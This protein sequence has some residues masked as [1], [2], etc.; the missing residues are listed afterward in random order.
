MIRHGSIW[1]T[2]RPLDFA[3]ISFNEEKFDDKKKI[4]YC[5]IR[6]E[7]CQQLVGMYYL[8]KP[9]TMPPTPTGTSQSIVD[10]SIIDGPKSTFSSPV[11][12]GSKEMQLTYPCGKI[13]YLRQSATG[14]I[15]NKTILLGEKNLVENAID[16]LIQQQAKHHVN[17]NQEGSGSNHSQP[18]IFSP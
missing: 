18:I 11:H 14:V 9:G 17:N 8:H 5:D 6:C 16:T 4:A 13:L 1:T 10:N 15:F 7:M 3:H 12:N 2:H